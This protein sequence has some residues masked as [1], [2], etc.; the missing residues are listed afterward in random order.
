MRAKGTFANPASIK[1]DKMRSRRRRAAVSSTHLGQ[2][3]DRQPACQAWRL[4]QNPKDDMFTHQR[5]GSYFPAVLLFL[6]TVAALE[7]GHGVRRIPGSDPATI[8]DD[9]WTWQP[10]TRAH[11]T[12]DAKL[13]ELEEAEKL[14]VY[15]QTSTHPDDEVEA[16][17]EEISKVMHSYKT[18][19]TVVMGDFNT[20]LEKRYGDVLRVRANLEL[21]YGTPE[22]GCWKSPTRKWTWM[23][24]DGKVKNEIDFIMSTERP[25]FNDVSVINTVKTGSDHQHIKEA[26]E[27]NKGSEVFARDLSIGQS[28]LTKLKTDD[29]S[30]ISSKSEILKE[31]E[32]FYRQL[33]FTKAPVESEAKDARAKLTRH[34]TEDIPDLNRH[35]SLANAR[36]IPGDVTG[37]LIDAGC[38]RGL[39][40]PIHYLLGSPPRRK[41]TAHTISCMWPSCRHGR[42]ILCPATATSHPETQQRIIIRRELAEINS[43]T[44]TGKVLELPRTQRTDRHAAQHSTDAV[45]ARLPDDVAPTPRRRRHDRLRL[46]P[47]LPPLQMDKC[48]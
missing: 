11:L 4:W 3:C 19:Y 13:T 45:A 14:L 26:I 41:E 39:K 48:C 10:T 46:V 21:D 43:R 34:Y 40:R 28:Q 29:G 20:K 9:D 2:N 35:S 31:V 5:I 37:P 30:I 32:S 7:T 36:D 18:H 12:T 1:E 17:H 23:S 25:I 47:T 15:A 6:V 22:T 33:Y 16:M 42:K 27:Q 38:D 24:P 8:S 44:I